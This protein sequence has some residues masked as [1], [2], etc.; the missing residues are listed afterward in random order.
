MAFLC[1]TIFSRQCL[2]GSCRREP[3][4]PSPSSSP[5][6][7]AVSSERRQA[8]AGGNKLISLSAAAH[9]LPQGPWAF[10][11]T[12]LFCLSSAAHS[13]YLRLSSP[14]GYPTPFSRNFFI[15][16]C[17]LGELPSE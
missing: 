15:G 10:A 5:L 4:R 9:R 14:S 8:G 11:V 1:R 17:F 7:K 12:A 16:T 2:S 6:T 3:L 13:R